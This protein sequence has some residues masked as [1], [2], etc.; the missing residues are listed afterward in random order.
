MAQPGLVRPGRGV[1]AVPL[2]VLVEAGIHRSL[3]DLIRLRRRQ[4]VSIPQSPC[5]ALLG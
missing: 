3:C 4:R 2:E 5:I 1:D